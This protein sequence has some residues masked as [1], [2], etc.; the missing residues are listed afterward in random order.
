MFT[1][2]RWM[3]ISSAALAALMMWGWNSAAQPR[4]GAPPRPTTG[5]GPYKALMEMDTSL[6]D[7]TVY[8]PEDLSALSGATLPLVVWGNGACVNAGN[9]FSSFL[10]DISS[11]GFLAIALGPIVDRNT[12]APAAPPAPAQ[13]P[14]QQPTDTTQHRGTCHRPPL[15]R[16]R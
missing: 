14:I 2:W 6:P 15:T 10:T 12:A 7:H 4:G 8:R 9:S 11:Y 13:P 16:L 1:Q 3:A 5:S